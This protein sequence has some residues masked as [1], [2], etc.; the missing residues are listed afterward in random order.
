MNIH[1]ILRVRKIFDTKRAG[2][3]A[4]GEYLLVHNMRSE[5]RRQ[6]RLIDRPVTEV[7]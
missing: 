1:N 6:E 7:D 3:A 5:I 4:V 2:H